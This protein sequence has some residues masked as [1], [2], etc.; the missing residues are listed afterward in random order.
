MPF[1]RGALIS[2]FACVLSTAALARAI[3][4]SQSGTSTSLGSLLDG[5][6]YAT[7]QRVAED[8][9]ARAES[10]HGPTSI[11]TARALDGLV[12][13]LV[14]NGGSAAAK[15]LDQAE[16]ALNLKERHF[17]VSHF[18]V[19]ISLRNLGAL[20]TE[21]GE[22]KQAA[23]LHA[24]ALSIRRRAFAADA[25]E[26]VESLEDM[27]LPLIYQE[28]FREAQ[29]ALDEAL[30]VRDAA[31]TRSPLLLA[32][33]LTLAA[34]LRR[35]DGNYTVG[36]QF[37]DR[38]LEIRRRLSPEHPATAIALQVRGDLQF[39]T[40]DIAAARRTWADALSLE[41]RVLRRGHPAMISIYR[42]LAAAANAFGERA[43]QHQLLEQALQNAERS[44]APCSLEF[45]RVLGDMA[46]AALFD[47]EYVE[48]Q[49]LYARARSVH[50]RCDGPKN[51]DT[52]TVIFNQAN[53]AVRMGDIALAEKRYQQ[54]IEIWTKAL[55]SGHPYVAMGLDAHADVLALRGL[56]TRSSTLYERALRIRQRALGPEH[57]DVAWTLVNLARVRFR[58]GSVEEALRLAGQAVD[59][60]RRTGASDDPDHFARALS[61]MAQIEISRGEYDQAELHLNDALSTRERIFGASDPLVAETRAEIA[62]LDFRLGAN[63]RSL[64]NALN[65]E[66]IGREHLRTTVRYLPERQA[67]TYAARRP[68]ALDLALSIAASDRSS[69]AAQ[70][71]D[72]AIRSRSVVLDELAARAKAA[73]TSDPGLTA[74]TMT[75]LAA[76]QRFA[77]LML[78]NYT[79]PGSVPPTMLEDARR[80]KEEAEAA[81][82]E[83]SA[84]FRNERARSEI[85][86]GEVRAALPHDSALVAFVRYDRLIMR[87]PGGPGAA[88]SGPTSKPLPS[89]PSYIAFVVRTDSDMF[90]VPLG[91][92]AVVDHLVA[93]WRAQMTAIVGAASPTA[94]EQAYRTAGAAL[95]RR[96]WDPLGEHLT[97]AKT[98]FI[99]PDGTLSLVSFAALPVGRAQYLIEDGPVVHYVSA[100][101]DLVAGSA[102]TST[103]RGL[104]AVG[105]VAFDDPGSF[106][107]ASK[108]PPAGLRSA[109]GTSGPLS[110]GALAGTRQEVQ[111]VARLWKDS[112]ADLLTGSA[113]SERA[114]KRSAPGRRVLHLATHGFFLGSCASVPAVGTRSVG[115]LV[116]ER[117]AQSVGL[118]ES[119]LLQSGLALAGANRRAAAGPGD[120]DGI[121]TAEEVT[122]LNLDGVEWAVL[123]ACD[124]GLGV[125]RAS[126]GVL[127][128]RRAF[129]V[130]GVRT[131]VMSLWPVDDQAA[132]S[133]MLALYQ[134]RLQLRLSTSDAVQYAGLSMLRARRTQRESTHP[135]YWA[136]FVAAGDWR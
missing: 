93:D 50:E 95:R 106:A 86:L 123:S 38:A 56:E 71:F 89:T 32:R 102:S 96:V 73:Q 51:T 63:Q 67:L 128:L 54:A 87:R 12:E 11:E 117:A 26:I 36:T 17:G 47:S 84:A 28:R 118:D 2:I 119:P 5:G 79:E 104:L 10:E 52:G 90:V 39:L 126:E 134:G 121:L 129:Q 111:D 9:V 78:R 74:L 135:F 45:P 110:F 48:A 60:Y 20:R 49:K 15:T 8:E 3:P 98:V 53:L 57:P 85:G 65:A 40:G 69:D 105:G 43:E 81:L 115:G 136:A 16:R 130:A 112:P 133:W 44:L 88:S 83:R 114:F 24:R 101:R 108:R 97:G 109:C 94:A 14:L 19:A 120:E 100:E 34:L 59:I 31:A 1:R 46:S 92:A 18:E 22:F 42:R 41:D 75:L 122:A 127:G 80:E 27:A 23:S 35:Y 37:V 82:A 76:R 21:R 131:I 124:T 103:G 25:T 61:L 113:A 132:R 91:S 70:A 68:K 77:N 116:A 30:R 64:A 107:L 125:V 13:S 58:A 4:H 6:D 55:G 29:S 62:A 7:A 72:S 33:T 66:R 99:V